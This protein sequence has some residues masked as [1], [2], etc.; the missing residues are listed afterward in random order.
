VHGVDINCYICNLSIR[1][2]RASIGREAV[3][4]W[5]CGGL[6]NLGSMRPIP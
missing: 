6:F 5:P 4:A 2:S 1:S 3:D